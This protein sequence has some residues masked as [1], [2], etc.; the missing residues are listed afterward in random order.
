MAWDVIIEVRRKVM[1]EDVETN[2]AS[3]VRL[4][5]LSLG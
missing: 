4:T 3:Y 1:T 2:L 5:S